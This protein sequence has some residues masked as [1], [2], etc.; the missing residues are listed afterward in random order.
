MP[1]ETSQDGYRT[2][3]EESAGCDCCPCLPSPG[4]RMAAPMLTRVPLPQRS[5]PVVKTP[6]SPHFGT[7]AV[8]A[9]RLLVTDMRQ[10]LL[11]RP[12]DEETEVHD[13]GR[14]RCL[15]GAGRAAGL[16]LRLSPAPPPAAQGVFPADSEQNREHVLPSR[17]HRPS[18]RKCPRRARQVKAGWKKTGG[19]GMNR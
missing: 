12:P 10:P 11:S 1:S 3:G 16:P 9:P 18:A 15:R 6:I 8:A 14:P 7:P 13:S 17:R 2:A 5:P 4:G 19:V